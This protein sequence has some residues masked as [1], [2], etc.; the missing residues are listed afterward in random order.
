MICLNREEDKF[1]EMPHSEDIIVKYI[2]LTDLKRVKRVAQEISSQ[3]STIDLI[4]CNAGVLLT[5]Y[6]TTEDGFETHYAVN[7]LSHA[8]L[9]ENLIRT[10]RNAKWDSYDDDDC[11]EMRIAFVSSITAHL[12][13]LNRR[14]IDDNSFFKYYSNGYHAYST[15]KL[16]VSVYARMLHSE[17]EN[18]WL[19]KIISLHPGV[20][21]SNLYRNANF[22]T[23]SLINGPLRSIMR[24]PVISAAEILACICSNTLEGGY[25][26][27]HMRPVKLLSAKDKALQKKLYQNVQRIVQNL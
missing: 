21:S 14:P 24:S 20:V 15:S 26:Y 13:D 3:F 12:G 18:N 16:A 19:I 25:Y 5:P 2:N 9:V 4:I 8:I 6:N 7:L 1:C 22:L 11:F 27:Q 17:T 23:R 10:R